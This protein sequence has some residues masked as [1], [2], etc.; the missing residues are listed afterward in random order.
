MV[1]S[2]ATLPPK[3]DKDPPISPWVKTFVHEFTA[4]APDMTVWI[5]VASN[6]PHPNNGFFIDTVGLYALDEQ[7]VVVAR[8]EG[9][10]AEGELEA[11][12][13]S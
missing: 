3:E 11:L 13:A 7:G 9:V 5:E 4:T 12:L 1:C 6:Y 10:L 8:I 2:C